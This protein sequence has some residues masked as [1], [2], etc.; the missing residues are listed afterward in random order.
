MQQAAERY[1]RDRFFDNQDR[2]A[3][4]GSGR[5]LFAIGGRASVT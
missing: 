2:A 5:L 1:R 4:V 3:T